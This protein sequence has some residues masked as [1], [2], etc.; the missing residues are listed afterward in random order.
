MH[1]FRKNNEGAAIIEFAIVG[2]ALFLVLTGIIELGLILF[3]NSVMEGAT[4]VGSRLGKTGFTTGGM[5]REDYIRSEILRLS[6]GY[7]TPS[8]LNISILS[9][10]SFSNIGQPEPCIVPPTAPCP[11]IPGVNFVDINGNT[12][13]DQDQGS[14]SAGG[15]GSVVLY[16]VTYPWRLFTPLMSGL[17]GTGGIYTIT[18]VAAV[19]NEQFR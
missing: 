11:G 2:P 6:G 1:S 19:R 4:N 12:T 13:W 7:L 3:T 8:S 18:A 17:L 9:Y 16:R 5:S 14:T 15:S 10:N